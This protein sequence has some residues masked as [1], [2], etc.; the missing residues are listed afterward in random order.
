MQTYL[1]GGAVRDKLLGI[2]VYDRDWVVIGATPEQMLAQ[3]FQPVGQDFPVF[4]HPQTGE[5]YAL[6]RTERKSGKGYTG[7]VYH[8]APDITL[9]QD[10]LRRDLT[11]NAMAM[12]SNGQIIDPYHGQQDLE[13]RWLRHVSPAFGE[14]P[15]R[16]LRVARFAARLAPFG[17][18]VA[19]ETL[20]LMQ[21]LA[22][23]DELTHLTAERV[24][25]EL[26]RALGETSP[27]T[28]FEIL[29]EAEALSQ[30]FPEC[31]R[32][33]HPTRLTRFRHICCQVA[34][35]SQRFACFLSLCIGSEAG[36]TEITALCDRLRSPNQFRDLALLCCQYHQPLADFDRLTA[37]QRLQVIQGL[38]LLRRPQRLSDLMPCISALHE[39][40]HCAA[41]PT[42]LEKMQRLQPRQLM[43]QGF[44]GA[45][46]GAELEK[47][48]LEICRLKP[49]EK[50][51][52]HATKPR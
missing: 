25:K 2:P 9:E 46:L 35:P 12:D 29:A 48:R 41:L 17:F 16:V 31:V 13:Q 39:Q 47:R 3:G 23:G 10:L 40:A 24:W 21:T 6:A 38:D 32:I 51:P 4:I 15:L 5:E 37:Q 11:I 27:A 22:N 1:V 14:D 28:F 20:Q 50:E 45:A 8:A 49:T 26:E 19:D 44:S 36:T 7:F 34:S 42:I 30:L 52:D 18:K 33:K 43:S